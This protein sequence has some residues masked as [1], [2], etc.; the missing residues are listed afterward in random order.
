MASSMCG[1]ARKDYF[2]IIGDS[3]AIPPLVVAA[4]PLPS[5]RPRADRC[6]D[7]GR[8]ES[9]SLPIPFCTASRFS[10]EYLKKPQRSGP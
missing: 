1:K 9:A 6:L 8:S 5:W 4:S 10:W 2:R 7:Y 3:S